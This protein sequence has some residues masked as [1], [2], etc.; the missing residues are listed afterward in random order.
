MMAPPVVV[1]SIEPE[2]MF[3]MAR[4]VV[5]APWST[6]L[7]EMVRV[8]LMVVDADEMMPP[9]KYERPLEV[10]AVNSTFTRREVDD[11]LIPFCAQIG[12]VVAALMAP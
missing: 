8:L 11:A 2:V 6:V 9:K 10:A 3:E 1:L 5:V 12:E 4:A 7:P